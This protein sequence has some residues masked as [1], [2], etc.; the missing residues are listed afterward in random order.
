MSISDNKQS[1]ETDVQSERIGWL[2]RYH[3]ALMSKQVLLLRFENDRA[4]EI[5]DPEC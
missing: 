3:P 5:V 1:F 2:I 4:R